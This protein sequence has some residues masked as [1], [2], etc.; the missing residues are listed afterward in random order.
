M[1][2]HA[3]SLAA[4]ENDLGDEGLIEESRAGSTAAFEELWRRHSAAGRRVAARFTQASDP[5][6]LV[7][8]AY[9]RIY[10]AIQKGKGPDAAF[11][12]YLYQTIR[13]IAITWAGKPAEQSITVLAELSDGTDMSGTVLENSVTAKAFRNLPERW[14]SVLW[15]SE[16]EG[17]EPAEIAP[18]LGIK[19]SAVSALAYRAREGLRKEWLQVHVNSAAVPPECTWAA[20]RM[21]DFNRGGL[22]GAAKS[23]FEEHVR[24]CSRCMVLVDEVD[25]VSRKLGLIM[26]PLVAGI[27][28]AAFAAARD[29]ALVQPV[30]DATSMT[31]LRDGPV[32]G[33]GA[34]SA[35]QA[36]NLWTRPG[37]V[38]V[39]VAA[40][41]ALFAMVGA[42]A[43]FGPWSGSSPSASPSVVPSTDPTDSTPAPTD[44]PTMSPSTTPTDLTD[45]VIVPEVPVIAP[46]VEPTLPRPQPSKEP[47]P[48]VTAPVVPAPIP[49]PSTEPTTGPTTEPTT[50]PTTGPTTEPT[51]DPTTE[52][53][54]PPGPSVPVLN[55]PSTA[56][57]RTFLPKMFGT[58]DAGTTVVLVDAK[59]QMIAQAMADDEGV[60][61]AMIGVDG[62]PAVGAGRWPDVLSAESLAGSLTI[63]AHA[64]DGEGRTSASSTAVG[65]YT[66]AES[67]EITSPAKGDQV[68][69]RGN[70]P[71]NA[72]AGAIDVKISGTKDAYVRVFVDGKTSGALHKLD[73]DPIL[74]QSGT[75]TLGDH[76]IGIQYVKTDDE[77][78]VLEAG[79]VFTHSFTIIATPGVPTPGGATPPGDDIPVL[80]ATQDRYP[81]VIV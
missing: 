68:R 73:T 74:R 72:L 3:V 57:E 33:S 54:D 49:D 32:D 65:P 10:S 70:L 20:E 42:A 4:G 45:P 7:Q 17:L 50:D 16:V 5:D 18:L 28:W 69:F 59:G 2:S 6:D 26:I 9:L 22:R 39:A 31:D 44:A 58:A 15:Y 35:A 52:P 53:T 77:T 71:E 19:A 14:Q 48:D 64:V 38:A 34:S 51:T 47:V 81:T 24:G 63:T 66:F 46:T 62:A 75:L 79:P 8:E 25:E 13:N 29:A 40:S 27:P 67:A 61:S 11:R 12:P 21:G 76:T 80:L 36:R 78:T 30:A 23:R 43:L 37:A 55:G 1:R 56:A 60:W 41:V